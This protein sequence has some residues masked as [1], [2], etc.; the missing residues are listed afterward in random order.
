MKNSYQLKCEAT[1]KRCIEMDNLSECPLCRE[2]VFDFEIVTWFNNAVCSQCKL[3]WDLIHDKSQ[4][5]NTN[6]NSVLSELID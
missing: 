1:E 2:M 3:E 6:L 5:S 4:D